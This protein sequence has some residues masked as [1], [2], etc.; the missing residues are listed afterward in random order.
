MWDLHRMN[1]LKYVSDAQKV[2]RREAQSRVAPRRN[3]TPPRPQRV[4]EQYNL[5][6]TVLHYDLLMIVHVHQTQFAKSSE[7]HSIG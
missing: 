7:V 6:S 4:K 3:T 5:C 1:F 2:D